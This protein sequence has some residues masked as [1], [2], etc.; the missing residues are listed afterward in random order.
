MEQRKFI[1]EDEVS[2]KLE[3][4]LLTTRGYK[5]SAV[6][7]GLMEEIRMIFDLVLLDIMIPE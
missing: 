7:D 1:V 2:L 4:I 3:S 5:V 6:T